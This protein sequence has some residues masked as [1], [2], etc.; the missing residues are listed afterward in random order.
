M[1]RRVALHG[2]DI[3]GCKRQGVKANFTILH[4]KSAYV[5]ALAMLALHMSA[6]IKALKTNENA[7]MF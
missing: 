5:L 6:S 7:S 4:G 1:S 3:Y 2:L